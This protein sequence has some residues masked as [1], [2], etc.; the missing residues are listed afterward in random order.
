MSGST[1]FSW[2]ELL[3]RGQKFTAPELI[4]VIRQTLPRKSRVQASGLIGRAYIK[5]LLSR[6]RVFSLG[7][8]YEYWRP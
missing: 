5:N 2:I 7:N 6:R 3:D 1:R 4:T 8:Q